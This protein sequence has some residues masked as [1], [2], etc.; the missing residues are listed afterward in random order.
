MKRSTM[1]LSAALLISVGA[2][3]SADADEFE[4]P[5]NLLDDGGRKIGQ[6]PAERVPFPFDD[7]RGD[8]R[9]GVTQAGHVYAALGK[10]LCWSEDGGRNWKSRNLP[11]EAGG[12]GVLR[13]D[14]FILFGGY[15]KCWV[16]R[17]TD[18]G[19]SWSQKS[20]LDVSPFTSCGGGWTQ[21]S[22]PPGCPALMVVELRHGTASKDHDGNPLTADKL[23]IHDYVFRS[24]DS[25]K[26][27]GNKS[28]IV[29]DSN[30]SSLLLLES[31]KMLAAIRK[32][33]APQRLLPGEN[34]FRLKAMGAWREGKPFVKHGFL[35]DSDD[36]GYTWHQER[37]G[38]V[39]RT[40]KY[41]LCPSE[42][43]QLADGCVVWIYTRKYGDDTTKFYG[44]GQGIFARVSTDEGA[45]WSAERY[46]VRL[47]KQ[48]GH[49]P[50]PASTVLPDGT[51]L[52]VMG[53][54][55]GPNPAMAVRWRLHQ[56]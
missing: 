18:Y 44:K 21:V 1:V 19:R 55:R 20:P 48:T 3:V 51:I 42:L 30:E 45:T 5:I 15:P 23:G 50:Y 41:G 13:D 22:Q 17:S 8:A 2:I 11:E 37:L 32:Q 24:T 29:P 25:G 47:L 39:S 14:T 6:L 12:F 9:L 31:G 27:W 35:A 40:I 54:N 10:K 43:V 52:T 36:K 46:C 53:T 4:E 38:P 33:R 16:I 26:T 56:Q 49:T 34:V 28:L 7:E